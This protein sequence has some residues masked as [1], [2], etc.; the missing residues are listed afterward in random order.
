M[1]DSP[2]SA[3]APPPLEKASES[4]KPSPERRFVQRQIVQPLIQWM[5]LGGSG[6]L[7]LSFLLK[8]EW[9]QGLIMFPVTIVTAVWAAY[10]K[11]FIERLSEIYAE[12]GKQDADALN[13]GMDSLNEALKWQL[14]GFDN[15]YLKLQASDCE[16]FR[17]EGVAQQDRIFTP[18]LKEVFIPL[19][20]DS[21]PLSPGLK[22][23]AVFE[24]F[25]GTTTI[26]EILARTRQEPMLR[27]LV[28]QAWGG[29]GKTTLLKHIAY[30][31]GTKQQ[32]RS[33]P[34]LIP[35]LLI[36]RKYRDLLAQDKP[37]SL[38]EL[39]TR[40]HIAGL[41]GAKEL[42]V[43]PTWAKDMLKRGNALVML[44]GFDEVAKSQRPAVARWITEQ[45]RQY[46][47]SVFIRPL[48]KLVLCYG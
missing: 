2:K 16:S 3:E 13:K 31:Y 23:Q 41:P 22:R 11:S 26:W 37:P 35:V 15:K 21:S 19:R 5:P 33:V 9:T 32:P 30:L 25:E 40:H 24:P 7:F 1:A 45:L 6:G 34:K 20:L 48:A 18:L 39:I 8:Q 10:S 12:K 42:Q 36:L 27:E 43:P 44:D 14:S 47:K 38:P 29:Y 17:S 28:I 46:G 4:R